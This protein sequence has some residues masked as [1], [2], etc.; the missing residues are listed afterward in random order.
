MSRVPSSWLPRDVGGGAR[1]SVASLVRARASAPA[2]TT[3][4]TTQTKTRP[5]SPSSHV[6]LVC[7]NLEA[8]LAFYCDVIGLE[9]SPDRPDSKLPYRGAWLKI[10]PEMIQ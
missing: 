2:T 1:A 5:S 9:V 8:S 10:G 7:A 4:T 3:T 6:G